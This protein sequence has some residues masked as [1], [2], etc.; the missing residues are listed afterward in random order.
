[1]IIP[2]HICWESFDINFERRGISNYSSTTERLP[3]KLRKERTYNFVFIFARVSYIFPKDPGEVSIIL[4]RVPQRQP[5]KNDRWSLPATNTRGTRLGWWAIRS[6]E[7]C[8]LC[9]VYLTRREGTCHI[10]APPPSMYTL[11]YALFL[12]IAQRSIS[13]ILQLVT[14]SFSKAKTAW[15]YQ[16][17]A[18]CY[19]PRIL[20]RYLTVLSSILDYRFEKR[21]YT[22]VVYPQN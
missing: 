12:I 14:Q 15:M 22:I 2:I 10:F 6:C 3:A 7:K 19:T 9:T 18:G 4:I 20:I 8:V 13:V 1:M 5:S 11:T 21:G 16:H 17:D